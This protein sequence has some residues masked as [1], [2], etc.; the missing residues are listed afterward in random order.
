[1][2]HR[3]LYKVWEIIFFKHA[4][5]KEKWNLFGP[6]PPRENYFVLWS[7]LVYLISQTLMFHRFVYIVREIGFFKHAKKKIFCWPYP[8]RENYFVSW[9][10][11]VYQIS[12]TLMF[13]WFVY[14]VREINFFKQKKKNI[15]LG[16]SHQEKI[17]LSRGKPWCIKYL[18]L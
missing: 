12:Q 17:I 18:K 5:L 2:F 9:S 10:T 16:P 6:H 11:L 14:K 4:N 1:M 15:F 13:H 3:F 8:P 7:T